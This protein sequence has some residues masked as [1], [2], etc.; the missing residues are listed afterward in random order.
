MSSGAGS[1]AR[2]RHLVDAGESDARHADG[3][4]DRRQHPRSSSGSYAVYSAPPD[5]AD[6]DWYSLCLPIPPPVLSRRSRGLEH[7]LHQVGGPK[8]NI[9][10]EL[11]TFEFHR[12]VAVLRRHQQHDFGRLSVGDDG[13][14][15]IRAH[16]QFFERPRQHLRRGC[17]PSFP[18]GRYHGLLPLAR[19]ESGD[20]GVCR[21]RLRADESR[22]QHA[23]LSV[24]FEGAGSASGRVYGSRSDP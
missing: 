13:I 4:A 16:V 1:T 8:R 11:D 14:E 18:V 19:R 10:D 3:A 2:P 17:G 9:Q 22:I 5:S 23:A 7:Q 15:C 6:C 24:E 20:H 21:L 12:C